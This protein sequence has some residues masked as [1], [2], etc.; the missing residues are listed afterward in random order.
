MILKQDA[1]AGQEQLILESIEANTAKRKL[2]LE[3]ERK[4]ALARY[5]QE[6]VNLE[7]DLIQTKKKIEET[8]KQ[9]VLKEAESG[10]LSNFQLWQSTYIFLRRTGANL[11]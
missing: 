3:T 4:K 8:T 10:L 6:T 11:V 7:T 9:L 1:R 5:E 2:E